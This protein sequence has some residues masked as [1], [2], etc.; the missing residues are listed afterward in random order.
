MPVASVSSNDSLAGEVWGLAVHPDFP[1]AVTTGDDN[2]VILW[3]LEAHT[4]LA[5]T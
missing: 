1:I 4:V 5:Q 2:T 3:D